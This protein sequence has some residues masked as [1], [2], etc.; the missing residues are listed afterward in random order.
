MFSNGILN[1]F[2]C[3]YYEKLQLNVSH[4]SKYRHKN[5]AILISYSKIYRNNAKLSL[6]L[7]SG[8]AYVLFSRNKFSSFLNTLPVFFLPPIHQPIDKKIGSP[9]GN[10]LF[11]V[12][13]FPTR[14]R[15]MP[16]SEVLR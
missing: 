11:S 13:L 9:R 14:S 12:P 8:N 15:T 10:Y 5:C 4:F 2:I 1:F 7:S 3:T 16:N 6:K